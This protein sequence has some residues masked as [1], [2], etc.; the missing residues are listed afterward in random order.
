MANATASNATALT[1][2]TP[3]INGSRSNI[4]VAYFG[5]VN[6]NPPVNL[7]TICHDDAFDIVVLAFVHKFFGSGGWPGL[8]V[9]DNC[10][11]P[12]GAQLA[13]GAADLVD[14]VSSGLADEVAQCQAAGKKILL[15]LGGSKA[16]SDT[17]IAS[18]AQAIELSQTLSALFL[19][20]K[21]QSVI[22]IR[23]FGNVIFDG[24]DLGKLLLSRTSSKLITFQITN[25]E[26]R[27]TC[28]NF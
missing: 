22:D 25:L 13:A 24:F 6:V 12:S 16:Y 4:V 20:P 2:L 23:P 18:D 9:A 1:N 8:N 27:T 3:N 17:S 5:Q 21:N 15:S 10:N 14:C 11:G 19:A 7:S 28:Y 26:T